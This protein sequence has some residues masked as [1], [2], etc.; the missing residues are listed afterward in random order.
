MAEQQTGLSPF[1]KSLRSV[2]YAAAID[3]RF[4]LA[5]RMIRQ[6]VD[7]LYK[8]IRKTH[9][10]AAG[11]IVCKDKN[12]ADAVAAFM[13]DDLNIEPL[14]IY[15]DAEGAPPTP[16][17]RHSRK[18]PHAMTGSW[19]CSRFQKASTSSGFARLSG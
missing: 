4:N 10:H 9:G 11:L 8:D 1:V 19:L 18:S 12:H 3:I 13:K 6:A 2:C 15:T 17:S 5:R 7:D 14:V 16:R